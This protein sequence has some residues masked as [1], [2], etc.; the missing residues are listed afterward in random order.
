MTGLA[1]LGRIFELGTSIFNA[2]GVVRKHM[3][4]S[5]SARAR[6]F[7][8]FSAC[9]SGEEVRREFSRSR[10]GVDKFHASFL[11]S[12]EM[13]MRVIRR[14]LGEIH[15]LQLKFYV[16]LEEVD[17]IFGVLITKWFGDK[18]MSVD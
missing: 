11:S 8:V 3:P 2:R 13:D 10:Q 6:V 9:R 16:G 1:R 7:S 17:L 18:G 5:I 12:V 14:R 4:I 15:A